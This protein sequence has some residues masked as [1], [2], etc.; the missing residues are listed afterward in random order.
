[1]NRASSLVN[2]TYY[3]PKAHSLIRVRLAM[4]RVEKG[5]YRGDRQNVNKIIPEE[6]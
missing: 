1:M 6:I 3:L 5:N 2:L 4:R